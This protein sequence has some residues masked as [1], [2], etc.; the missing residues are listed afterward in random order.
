[1]RSVKTTFLILEAVAEH[2]PIGLSDL[3]RRMELPKTTVQRSLA[4]LGQLGWIR[5]DGRDVTRWELSD[6]VRT[7][8]EHVGLDARLRAAALP[9]LGRLHADTLETIHLAVADG[10]EVRLIERLES[11]HP[12]RL[13]QPIGSRSALHASSN[14]KSV[15]AHL[16]E[17]ELE[18][19][20]DGG[21]PSMTRNTITDRDALR[22]ELDAVRAQRYA[23]ADQELI[24]G[25][26]SV[27]A[28]IRLGNGRPVAA[29]SISGPST[30]VVPAL[31]TPYGRAVAAA[32]AEV[33]ARLA[34]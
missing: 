19:Y 9:V 32:A 3:A 10:R 25:I 2:Q 20:I 34:P 17:R 8:S 23:V 11:V 28:S 15:L 14:G 22:E 33:S 7:L 24:D 6:R 5:P 21:L 29:M 31:F 30:R 1:M 27:A 26:S 4:T 18:A 16:P 13:V 12:L